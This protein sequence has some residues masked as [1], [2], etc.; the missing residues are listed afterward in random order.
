[1]RGVVVCGLSW[2]IADTLCCSGCQASNFWI[3][4]Q[5]RSPSESKQKSVASSQRLRS[6]RELRR[7][8]LGTDSRQRCAPCA[9]WLYCHLIW[10]RIDRWSMYR[11]KNRCASRSPRLLLTIMMVRSQLGSMKLGRILVSTRTITSVEKVRAIVSSQMTRYS[12]VT[13]ET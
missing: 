1:M 5:S 8:M 7:R 3:F 13:G 2:A 4:R 6:Q 9:V 10:C 11:S 12:I